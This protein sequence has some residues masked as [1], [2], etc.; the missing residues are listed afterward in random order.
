MLGAILLAGI[1][2][3]F[4][5]RRRAADEE[6]EISML[7]I[8]SNSQSID[9]DTDTG[10]S[11]SMSASVADSADMTASEAASAD[12]ETSFLTVYSDSDAVVQADEVDPIAEA[13]VYIAYGRDEQAEEVL[14]D[15][16]SANPDRLDVK[17]KLLGLYFKNKNTEGFERISEELFAQKDSIGGDQWQEISD[18]GKELL[19]DNPLFSMTASEFDAVETSPQVEETMAAD[20]SADM[21]AVETEDDLIESV[22]NE[23]E[24]LVFDTVDET[25]E[26]A[27]LA[28]A[29]EAKDSV[30]E[31]GSEMSELL[32]DSL[33]DDESIQLI[34]F[35]EGRSE[36]SQL[37]EVEIDALAVQESDD[38]VL[39]FDLSDDAEDDSDDGIEL[40]LDSDLDLTAELSENDLVFDDSDLD[41]EPN[42]GDQKNVSEVPEVSDL[43][44]DPDYDEAETQYELAKVFVDLGDE[45]GARKILDELVASE[46][47]SDELR[48][49]S[50]ELLDSMG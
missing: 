9:V 22:D 34:N 7:S 14:L 20:A 21:A 40:D 6:F 43:V 3:F 46:D 13:D 47:N 39:E 50:Q 26:E 23:S 49:K 12:K 30:N 36:I 38:G 24:M 31:L 29:D 28:L 8:E 27:A 10:L 19:P 37:D 41:D 4:V 5:R 48:K 42:V 33:D 15:G 44:I 18:M 32:A 25:S 1:A 16:I 35:D 2:V 45:D 11:A 17:Q